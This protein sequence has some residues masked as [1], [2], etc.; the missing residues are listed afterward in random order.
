MAVMAKRLEQFPGDVSGSPRRYPWSEWTDGGVW[1]IRRGADYDATTENMRVNLHIKAKSLGQ[2]VRT[3][4]TS[5]GAGLVFQ[6]LDS[7]EM[8]VV[9]MSEEREP[10]ATRE[11]LDALYEDAC[12]IYDTARA[13]VTIPRRDGSRQKYA[14]I[15]FKRQ[16]D[17]AREENRLVPT[18]AQIVKRPTVGLGHLAAA[19]RPDL[20]LESFVVDADKPYHRLFSR[21]TVELAEERLR[22]YRDGTLGE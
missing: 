2:K 5:D 17:T 4:K 12:W 13:E 1:E 14:A 9:R 19:K 22:E 8:E 3:T 10:D 18:V 6:F 15:R 16:I 21:P 20:M 11:A 7:E